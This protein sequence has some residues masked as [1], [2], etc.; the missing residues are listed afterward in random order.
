[1][2]GLDGAGHQG[3]VAHVAPVVGH[4]AQGHLVGV[5]QIWGQHGAVVEDLSSPTLGADW[6]VRSTLVLARGPFGEED[7][8]V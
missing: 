7:Q 6:G 1:M 8:G 5:Q 4:E 3:S 2:V